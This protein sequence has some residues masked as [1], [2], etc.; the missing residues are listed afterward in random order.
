MG[1]AVS[2]ERIALAARL[3][4]LRNYHGWRQE[5]VAASLGWSI[6]SYGDIELCRKRVYTHQL[7]ALA[8]HFRVSVGWLVAGE[9]GDVPKQTLEI[10][11]NSIYFN[12]R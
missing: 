12:L 9:R 3:K 4:A 11:D 2:P 6:N 8:K 10:I 5:D 1:K 7:M